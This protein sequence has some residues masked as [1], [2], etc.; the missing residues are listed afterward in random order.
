MEKAAETRFWDR[1]IQ[2]ARQEQ[3]PERALRW[4]VRRVEQYIQAHTE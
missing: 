4:Y 2:L 3:V 1:Y